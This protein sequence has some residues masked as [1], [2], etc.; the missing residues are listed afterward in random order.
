M[1]NTEIK[2]YDV[3]IYDFCSAIGDYR[4]FDEREF[5]TEGAAIQWAREQ[6]ESG[7]KVRIEQVSNV[8]G[9]EK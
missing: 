1:I 5:Y 4:Y 9:W 3:I 8:I 7:F 2:R 6:L